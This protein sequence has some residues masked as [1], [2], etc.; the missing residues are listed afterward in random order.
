MPTVGAGARPDDA[1]AII[2]VWGSIFGTQCDIMAFVCSQ[3]VKIIILAVWDL[4][5]WDRP[6]VQTDG[7]LSN[8]DQSL[9]AALCHHIYKK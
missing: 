7:I 4:R 5:Y 3:V 8:S 6:G 2:F 9:I 1:G